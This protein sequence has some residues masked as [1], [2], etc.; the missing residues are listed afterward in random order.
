MANHKSAEKRA[1]QTIKKTKQNNQRKSIV[2]TFE[3]K[4]IAAI[5]A[6]SPEVKALLSNYVSKAMAAVNK[7]VFRKETVA[8]KVGRLSSQVSKA[9]KQ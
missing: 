2:K 5:E 9:L 7:G 3:K 1:R 6:K 8:R 4:L